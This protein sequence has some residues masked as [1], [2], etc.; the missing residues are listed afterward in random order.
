MNFYDYRMAG[1]IEKFLKKDE[2]VLDLGAGNCQIALALNHKYS[3][4]VTPIDIVNNNKTSLKLIVYDGKNIP[5]ENNHFDASYVI[6]VLHHVD[7]KIELL[8]EISRVTQ[9]TMIIIEDTP[10]NKFEKFS[11]WI[12]DHLINIFHKSHFSHACTD[13]QWEEVFNQLGLKIIHKENFR[14]D[15]VLWSYQHTLFVLEKSS[16]V[17]N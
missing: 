10:K 15:F 13:S 6:F 14:T 3:L 1:K 4:N 7:S 12:F 17:D 5:F 16:S 8:K 2:I 9:K 11:W